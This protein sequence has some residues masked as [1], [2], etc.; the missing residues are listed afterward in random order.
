M[1][2][3]HSIRKCNVVWIV[4]LIA[5]CSIAE[6]LGRNES[7]QV[8]QP[9][10]VIEAYKVCETFEHVL[11][12]NLDFSTAF[13]ATFVKD[14]ARRRAIALKDGEFD[15]DLKVDDETIISAYKNRMQLLYSLLPLTSPDND[16]QEALFFPPPIRE[17]LKRQPPTDAQAF[18]AYGV[19]L[20]HDVVT[21][22]EHLSR[23]AA[24]NP[25]VAERI[26]KFKA[27]VRSRDFVPPNGSEVKPL[28][29]N[30][31][32]RVVKKN[33]PHYE[34][35]GY[36]VIREDSHMR[37]AGIRFFTRLF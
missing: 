7:S 5:A 32:G 9:E 12:E 30:Y 8:K 10:E 1:E 35:N 33:E 3:N 20:E 37:I 31:E 2:K 36:T 16:E 25:V 14:K 29:D 13:E 24:S 21:F 23:L 18:R 17:V 22:R 6:A 28:I 27:E 4:V 15:S 26:Q 11:A 34:I 19:Q